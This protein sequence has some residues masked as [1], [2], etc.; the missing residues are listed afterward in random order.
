MQFVNESSD[1]EKEPKLDGDK[2]PDFG[3]SENIGQF[4]V[5][6]RGLAVNVQANICQF[7]GR[8]WHPFSECPEYQHHYNQEWHRQMQMLDSDE[9]S[10]E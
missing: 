5:P 7:C 8:K 10:D 9:D 6:G 3:R 1:S 2:S 4:V